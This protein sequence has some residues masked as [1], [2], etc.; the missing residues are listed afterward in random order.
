MGVPECPSRSEERLDCDV[1][2][3]EPVVVIERRK[4]AKRRKTRIRKGPK[5]KWNTSLS[6]LLRRCHKIPSKY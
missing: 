2:L 3:K 5:V 4:R 6:F 1:V